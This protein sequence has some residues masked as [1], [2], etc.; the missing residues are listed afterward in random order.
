LSPALPRAPVK[1]PNRKERKARKGF[2]YA[3]DSNIFASSASSA[4]KTLPNR[5]ERKARKGFAY[6]L[7]SNIFASS[8]SFAVK[9]LPT[10]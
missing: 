1:N 3:L 9:T 7:D 6:A 5:K 10:F 2:A 4:V 8:A